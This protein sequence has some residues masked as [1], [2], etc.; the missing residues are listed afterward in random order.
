M[1]DFPPVTVVLGVL[2]P[3]VSVLFDLHLFDLQVHIP[4]GDQGIMLVLT[5]KAVQG[6]MSTRINT[7]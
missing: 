2:E 6:L 4:L 5:E 7:F 1:S 3:S